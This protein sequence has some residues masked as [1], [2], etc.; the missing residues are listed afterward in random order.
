MLWVEGE[1]RGW[2]WKWKRD[3]GWMDN[4]SA[5]LLGFPI[6]GNKLNKTCLCVFFFASNS[7]GFI[8]VFHE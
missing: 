5:G 3:D 1:G 2:E 6:S 8:S 4:Q 7:F